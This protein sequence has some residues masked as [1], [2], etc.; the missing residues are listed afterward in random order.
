MPLSCSQRMHAH[1]RHRL[2]VLMQDFS[3]LLSLLLLFLVFSLLLLCLVFSLVL[4]LASQHTDI[5]NIS[6]SVSISFQ[7]E[8]FFFYL[9]VYLVTSHFFPSLYMIGHLSLPHN[10]CV[11]PQGPCNCQT[12]GALFSPYFTWAPVASGSDHT[13]LFETHPKL[14]SGKFLC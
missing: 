5:L 14:L 1:P 7:T 9:C 12:E 11:S 2:L 10:P 8:P 13:F 3:L 4:P 6:V